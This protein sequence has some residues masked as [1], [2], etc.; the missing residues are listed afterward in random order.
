[1]IRGKIWKLLVVFVSIH[2][3]VTRGDWVISLICVVSV[4]T[5][6]G[7]DVHIAK[8]VAPYRFVFFLR[9]PELASFESAQAAPNVKAQDTSD[10]LGGKI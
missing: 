8:L 5:H 9:L 3:T 10:P 6:I 4:Y 1:M 2:P 7:R